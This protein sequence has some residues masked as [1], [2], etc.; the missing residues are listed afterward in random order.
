MNTIIY[1]SLVLAAIG[2]V[3]AVILYFVSQKFKVYEDPK[4]D[5]VAV[6]LPGANCGGCGF[7]GCRNF[8]ETIVKNG[9]L[10][11]LACPPGGPK[12]NSAIASV[13]GGGNQEDV[14]KI[15]IVRCNGSCENAPAKVQYDSIASCAWFNMLNAGESGCAFGC[16]G[17]GDCVKACKFDAIYISQKTKLPVVT[18]SC[19]FCGACQKACPRSIISIVPRHEQGV[20]YV[21]CVNQDKGGEAK[22]N[23]SVACIGCKK[24][25]KTCEYAAVTVNN[26]LANVN[27]DNCIACKKCVDGC[28]T[29]AIHAQA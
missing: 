15:T 10:N 19:V 14:P 6:L 11:G 7:A 8:A 23:C 21:A 1:S 20:V 26:N 17:C 13:F 25:E 28:P 29:K 12:V 18:S 22:K 9:G 3:A 27:E 24:C 16:L 4:I 2:I 5:E